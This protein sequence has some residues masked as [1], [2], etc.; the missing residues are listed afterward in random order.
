ME[1]IEEY[2]Q[3]FWKNCHKIE[4]YKKHIERIEKG[5]AAI[6]HRNSIDQ[7]IND[8]FAQLIN[9]F[10]KQYPDKDVTEFTFKDITLKYDR[11]V[12]TNDD[13]V[14]NPFEYS[15][16]EDKFYAF[17]LFKYTYGY[18]EIIKNELRNSQYFLFNWAVQLRTLAD[19]HKRCDYLVQL[20]KNELYDKKKVTANEAP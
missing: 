20:F 1:D 11:T 9:Q 19:I 3:V 7:A 16:E 10:Q 14:D 15:E 6:A 13:L 18:W 17:S 12:V 5:E 4:N 8:K 2:S